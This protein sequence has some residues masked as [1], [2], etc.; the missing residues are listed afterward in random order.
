MRYI[1]NNISDKADLQKRDDFNDY[2]GFPWGKRIF[3]FTR[4]IYVNGRVWTTDAPYRETRTAIEKRKKEGCI[5]V[6]MELAGLQAVCSY[7]GVEMY[8][9]VVTGDILDE[10]DDVQ[11]VY[12]NWDE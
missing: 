11:N 2:R 4:S 6:E 9:F 7:Y 5:A 1:Q 8:S 3:G 12:H 10:D